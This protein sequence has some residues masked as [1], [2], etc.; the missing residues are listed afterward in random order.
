MNEHFFFVNTGILFPSHPFLGSTWSWFFVSTQLSVSNENR[1][2]SLV[3]DPGT[4]FEV[5]CS[6]IYGDLM[7]NKNRL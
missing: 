7:G 5:Y 6:S 3:S 4:K 2:P 1:R